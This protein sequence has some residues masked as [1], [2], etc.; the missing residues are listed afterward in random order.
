MRFRGENTISA[1]NIGQLICYVIASDLCYLLNPRRLPA[2]L[3]FCFH[4]CVQ[5]ASFRVQIRWQTQG[6]Q[7]F[8]E[9]RKCA[10]WRAI[11]EEQIS[12]FLGHVLHIPANHKES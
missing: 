3:Q 2:N 7:H 11:L 10:H 4:T 9:A 12:V 8:S 1:C 6:T 5:A